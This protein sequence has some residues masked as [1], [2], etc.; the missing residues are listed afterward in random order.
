[1]DEKD[2][3]ETSQKKVK[4]WGNGGGL[5]RG[6]KASVKTLNVIIVVLILALVAVVVYLS[7]TSSYTITFEVNGGENISS[8][9]NKYGEYVAVETPVKTGYEFAG[10]YLDQDMTKPWDLKT[11]TVED[12]MTLY[13]KWNASTIHILFNLNGGS[14][15]GAGELP[16][17]DIA[18]HQPYG[19]LP[20]PVKEGAAFIGWQYNGSFIQEDTL[21]TMNGEHTLTAIFQ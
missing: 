20:T 1:M 5:Y 11:N 9:H 12:S 18:F 3:V 10:W 2:C 13:A 19:K 6:V 16:P 8:V 14:I 21:V 17:V 4:N 7:S 15:D